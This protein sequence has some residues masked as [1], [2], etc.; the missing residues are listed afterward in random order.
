[1]IPCSFES[2]HFT[3]N[4]MVSKAFWFAQPAFPSPMTSQAD[5]DKAPAA[6]AAPE[7]PELPAVP[8]QPKPMEPVKSAQVPGMVHSIHTGPIDRNSLWKSPVTTWVK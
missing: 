1:M 2:P 5:H 7:L 4:S 3:S 6:P 8:E